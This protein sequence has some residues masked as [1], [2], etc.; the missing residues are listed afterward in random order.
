MKKLV[1]VL[2]SAL[3]IGAVGVASAGESKRPS[4]EIG[5]KRL[6]TA[7][8]IAIDLPTRTVTLKGQKGNEFTVHADDRVKNLPQVRVGDQVDVAYHE[9]LVWNVKKAGE[10]TPGASVQS[11]TASAKPGAKPAGAA[12][13]QLN[14]TATIEAIDQANGT[15][16]LKGP[17][18]NTRTIKARDPKNLQRV[19][20][21]DLVDITYTEAVAV[22]VRPSMQNQ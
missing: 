5:R 12:A 10:G 16:T 2:V 21:G 17:Q 8:V 19:Q 13:T 1:F 7:E 15:V 22:R 18:G 9:S 3:C 20:V 6:A 4:G 14:M 11:G